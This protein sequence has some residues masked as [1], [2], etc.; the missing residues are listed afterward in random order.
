MTRERYGDVAITLRDDF[1]TV[2]EIQRPPHNFF[3]HALIRDLADAFDDLGRD[4]ACR[5]ILLCAQGKAFCA[6][7]NFG[8]G[9]SVL[10]SANPRSRNPLYDEAVRLFA[11]EKPVVAAIQGP[12]IGGGFGLAVMADFRIA[13]PEARFA[14]N[15]VKLG[16]HPGFGLTVTLPELI[17][18]QKALDL[19]LTGR[20]IDGTEAHAMGLVDRLASA[21][22]LRDEALAFAASIAENAPLAVQ[23][24]RHTLRRHLA[25]KVKEQTDREGAEQSWLA[26]TQDH[27]EGIRSVAER[28][29]GRFVG[30]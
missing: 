6:G 28:R 9:P 30:R 14:A 12:A 8:S 10:E 25:S 11:S 16:I 7:A 1:V 17:G 21:E 3:D 24:T 2:A 27:A 22:S 20:R 15:F 26:R 19:F 18:S 4:P 13:S 5:A 29:P 23:S